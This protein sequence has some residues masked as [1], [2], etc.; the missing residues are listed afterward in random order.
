MYGSFSLSSSAL[1]WP[2]YQG[3]QKKGGGRAGY[4]KPNGYG[5]SYY[6]L[7]AQGVDVSALHA[8]MVLA[9]H[10]VIGLQN[11]P[12]HCLGKAYGK[13]NHK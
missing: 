10:N 1:A 3:L 8:C 5:L 4:S 7:A 6:G 2:S 12:S 11:H 13:Y 9:T